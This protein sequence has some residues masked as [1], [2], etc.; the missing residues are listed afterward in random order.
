MEKLCSGF[1][2]G[3]DC[4]FRL[5]EVVIELQFEPIWCEFARVCRFSKSSGE[6]GLLRKLVMH[7]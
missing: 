3:G 2:G 7:L 4:F 6:A 1:D 5:A